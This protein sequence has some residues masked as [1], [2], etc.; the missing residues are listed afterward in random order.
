VRSVAGPA[1]D[2]LARRV[3]HHGDGAAVS[4]KIRSVTCY[5]LRLPFDHGGP[6][7]KFAG[8]IRTSLDSCLIRVELENGLIGWGEAY[9]GDTAAVDS[10]I[11]SRV[12]P[13]AIGQDPTDAALTAS[14]ERTLHNLGRSGLVLHALSGLDVA[15]WDIRGKLENVPLHVLLA[16]TSSRAEVP[17][18]ASLL[19]YYGDARLVADNVEKAL[20]AG[21]RQIKLH[22]RTPQAAAAARKVMGPTLPLMVDT[23]CAWAADEAAERVLELK[24]F[25][26]LY[27]EEPLWPPENLEG[28]EEL[29][30]ATGVATAVGENASSLSEL[31]QI[32]AS[33]RASYVQPSA[34]K[35][36]GVS[37]LHAL[38]QECAD[39]L[40]DFAPQSAFLGPGLLATVNVLA[41][42]H[43]ESPIERMFCRLEFTPYSHTLS[44]T[45]GRFRVPDRPGLGAQAWEEE[46]LFQWVSRAST[47]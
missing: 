31:H 5:P 39:S 9:G 36:G 46:E 1:L 38:S 29:R 44:L 23:N 2:D 3:R 11:R 17:A 26:L 22:E 12:G 21:F 27:I 45:N 4:K 14:I 10:L 33:G 6:P 15:L 43:D 42:A 18:Y 7:P 34:I 35:C 25:D 16:S 47:H 30:N 19:Q 37:A 13:L 41:A 20:S 28:L 40:V 24:P 32:I 8:L